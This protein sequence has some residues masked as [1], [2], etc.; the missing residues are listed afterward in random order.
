MSKKREKKN[1]DGHA[2]LTDSCVAY[3]YLELCYISWP[4]FR[5]GG[6]SDNPRGGGANSNVVVDI[7]CPLV[8]IG[9]TDLPKSGCAMAHP[10]NP[11]TTGLRIY[12]QNSYIQGVS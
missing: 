8:E 3:V 11:G 5:V 7:I 6:R 10:A 2:V 4:L 9:L 1:L 12:L